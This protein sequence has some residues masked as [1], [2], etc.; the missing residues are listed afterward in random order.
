MKRV[1]GVSLGSSKRDHIVETKMLGIDFHIERVGTD[2]NPAKAIE[3][4]KEND[5]KVDCFGLG[6]ADLYLQAGG[7]KYLIRDVARIASAARLTPIVDGGGLKNTLESKVVE[8]L[9]KKRGMVFADKNVLVVSAV[10]RFRL[11]ESLEAAGGNVYFGDLIFSLGIPI[12]VKSTQ[13]VAALA[14][15][16]LP[17]VCRLPFK[18]IYPTGKKQ[19]SI[20]RRYMRFYNWADI[21]AGD[22]HFIR[23]YMPETM[24]GKTIITNTVT[25]DDISL[26]RKR[27]VKTLVTTTPELNGRS[28]GANVIEAILVCLC[29]KPLTE[30]K[31]T[32][33]EDYIER[34]RLE[35][36]VEILN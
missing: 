21:I 30:I 26:L 36:R 10:D 4:I 22:F 7:R 6:G 8:Y 28:F 19:D 25:A 17:I 34:L 14:P 18:Y 20:S 13:M 29:E 9:I 5:G 12:P 33:Y 27:G 32:D 2:G 23:R 16:I 35:P 31:E 15:I 1:L 24:E 3:I 11:S